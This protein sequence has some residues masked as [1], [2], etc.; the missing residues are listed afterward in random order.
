MANAFECAVRL[1]SRRE[2]SAKELEAKL[3]QNGF[4]ATDVQETLAKCQ[5]LDLQ[6]EG[7]FVEMYIRSRIRQGYGP[8]KISQELS[9]KGVDK[10]LIQRVLQHEEAHWPTHALAVL[11]KKCKGQRDLSFPEM[12]KLQRFLLYR[13]F[14]MDV[15][16]MVSKDEESLFSR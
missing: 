11:Q 13:G 4:N 8:L 9:A 16:A 2:H 10:Q 12:Q 7:R 15:I 6:N 1:L 3:K 5:E 14:S